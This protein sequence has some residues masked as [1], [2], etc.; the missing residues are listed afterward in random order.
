MGASE[1]CRRPT[2]SPVWTIAADESVT[3]AVVSRRDLLSTFRRPDDDIRASVEHDVLAKTL[4][5]PPGQA[6]VTVAGGVVTLLG[7]RPAARP[8]L[9]PPKRTTMK[10]TSLA[11]LRVTMGSLFLRAFADKAFGFGYATTS[12]NAWVNGGSPTKG[13][14]SHIDVGPRRDTALAGR[15]PLGGLAVHD[16]SFVEHN[17]RLR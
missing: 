13:F 9:F 14:L 8:R 4:R 17:R 12:A 15:R 1:W 6:S 11:V 5:V 7:R 16:R 10:S 3:A 2:C